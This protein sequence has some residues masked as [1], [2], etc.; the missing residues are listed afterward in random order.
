MD[1]PGFAMENYDVIGGWR[2]E[3]RTRGQKGKQVID[4]L[5]KQG[6]QYRLG[7][8]VDASGALADGRTFTN[9]DELK[10]L[11]L[12]K[13]EVVARNLVNNLVAYATGAGVTFSDRAKVQ[14]IL[15]EAKGGG[16]GVR[17]LVH[18]LVESPLFLSK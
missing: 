5:T 1:P 7:A 10:K 13:Q 16:Y 11:L 18:G 9:L 12:E 15:D 3:Y 6:R 2:E 14:A 4:P 17:T 8:P